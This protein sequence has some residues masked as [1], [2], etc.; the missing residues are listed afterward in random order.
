MQEQPT[1]DI[2]LALQGGGSHGALAWGVID[3]LLD[4]TRFPI[5]A[6]SGTSAG[7]MNAVV[8]ASALATGTRQDAKD[9]L[10]AFWKDVSLA[11][12]TSPI[13]R[14]PMARWLGTWSLDD[15]P[16]YHW[17]DMM[18]RAVSPYQT[19]LPNFH[20]LEGILLR[21]VDFAA[22]NTPDAPRV[23]LTATNVRT[24]LPKVFT[25]PALTLKTVLASAALPTLFR[26]VEIEGEPYW[27]GGYVGNP[28]LFPLVALEKPGDLLIVQTNPFTRDGV[29]RSARDIANRLNE[30]T[31][32][33]ALLKELRALTNARAAGQY[34]SLRLH[35]VHGDDHLSEFAPSSKLN[36]EWA[37]LQH[38]FDSGH[39][40]AARFLDRHADNIG[41]RDTYDPGDMLRDII[42]GDVPGKT[43]A[44]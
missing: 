43:A 9:A 32:N 13:Q 37:Y 39:R 34:S 28:A 41:Q 16:A 4:E 6:I 29:P 26:A 19:T 27:D 21:H 40:Q 5:A 33:S 20:P 7:A 38:L 42:E 22:L 36:V 24:G 30:I 11:G 14:T 17:L 18:S 1:H 8:V 44:A 31:F 2:R 3:R 25:Q 15:S 12:R 10:R 35:R 23:Y